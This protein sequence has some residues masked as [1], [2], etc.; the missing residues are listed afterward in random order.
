[1]VIEVGYDPSNAKVADELIKKK[2]ADIVALKKQLKW[3]PTEH[4][5]AKEVLQ[6][7]NQKDEMMNLI[8]Q[9]TTQLKE[10]ENEMDKLVQEKRASSEADPVTVIPIVTTI[11]PSTLAESLAP[12]VPLATTIH[13][14][15]A[16]TLET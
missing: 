6:D 4:P 12:S 10:M 13:V 5:R 1:M 14:T 15:S 9:L 8:L 11:V 3:P 7:A 16:T 2:N